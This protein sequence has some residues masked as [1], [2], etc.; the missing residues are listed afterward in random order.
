M[1]CLC[2]GAGA[3]SALIDALLALDQPRELQV[4]ASHSSDIYVNLHTHVNGN[5][6]LLRSKCCSANGLFNGS[7]STWSQCRHDMFD[8]PVSAEFPSGSVTPGLFAVLVHSIDH[9]NAIG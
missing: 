6:T 8:R 3:G 1:L 2:V 5:T 4:R 9:L 7:V